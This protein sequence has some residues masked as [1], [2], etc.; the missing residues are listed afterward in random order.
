MLIQWF[1][2]FIYCDAFGNVCWTCDAP[3]KWI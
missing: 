2:N 1:S 3:T